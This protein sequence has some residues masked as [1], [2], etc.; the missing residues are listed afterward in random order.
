M[1]LDSTLRSAKS[2]SSYLAYAL[3]YH[4]DTDRM[5][6]STTALHNDVYAPHSLK[7]LHLLPFILFPA[8]AD[9][10]PTHKLTVKLHYNQTHTLSLSK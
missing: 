1:S 8:R 3:R 10:S 9:V 7:T 6:A 5:A 4:T 2:R